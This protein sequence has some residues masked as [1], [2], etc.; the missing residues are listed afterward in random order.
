MTWPTA[1][2]VA[3]GILVGFALGSVPFLQYG[4]YGHPHAT[5][6]AHAHR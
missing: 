2:R 3:V 6:V 4:P 5:H 1:V